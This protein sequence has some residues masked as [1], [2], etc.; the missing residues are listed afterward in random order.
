MKV[1]W[2][3]TRILKRK[4]CYSDWVEGN[5]MEAL[6][7]NPDHIAEPEILLPDQQDILSVFKNF[8]FSKILTKQECSI[9]KYLVYEGISKELICDRMNINLPHFTRVYKNIRKKLIKHIGGIE[10]VNRNN[11]C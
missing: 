8:D 10:N 2:Q 7:A 4:M 5:E 11:R 9:L 6:R 1:E 3:G